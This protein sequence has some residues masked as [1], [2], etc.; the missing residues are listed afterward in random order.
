MNNQ[1]KATVSDRGLPDRQRAPRARD[2]RRMQDFREKDAIN[3]GQWAESAEHYETGEKLLAKARPQNRGF[4]K[5][6]QRKGGIPQPSSVETPPQDGILY[7][8]NAVGSSPAAYQVSHNL[9]Y[10][11][12]GPV[13]DATYEV[14]QAANPQFQRN[15]PFCI[16]Q[17][18]SVEVLNSYILH[19]AK[20]KKGDPLMAYHPD[21]YLEGDFPEI[22]IPNTF[23][24]YL[25]G[26]SDTIASDGDVINTNLP[27]AA[28]PRGPRQDVPS[29]TF[30]QCDVNTH[31]AYECYWSPYVSRRLVER[32]LDVNTQQPPTGNNAQ[33]R[34]AYTSRFEDWNPLPAEYSPAN[35]QANENLL[36]YRTPERLRPEA[37]NALQN[38]SF[39]NDATILGRICH[40]PEIISRVSGFVFRERTIKCVQFSTVTPT[41][42]TANL[43]FKCNTSELPDPRERLA[44]RQC[45]V[46]SFSAFS[47]G[48]SN[49][50][51][52]FGYKRR[53]SEESPGLCYLVNNIAIEGWVDTRNQNFEMTNVYAP[54]HGMRDRPRLR[55]D[56]HRE[57]FGTGSV[58]QSLQLWFNRHFRNE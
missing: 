54:R 32:T 20:K 14:Y 37:I 29:G 2:V 39:Y 25:Q 8:G 1:G 55:E 22:H 35:A 12:F 5:P 15:V 34:Q 58:P 45:P 11:G 44:N 18:Y 30:G 56:D 10:S 38:V 46:F 53:R 9:D 16:F 28:F 36:G 48:L 19:L 4:R 13:I 27:E 57:L 24:E 51:N 31:N 3:R 7:D 50:C 17:H 42:S 40:S 33:V 26:I 41:D 43:I 23:K 6:Q 52:Y 21:P 47:A 49:R